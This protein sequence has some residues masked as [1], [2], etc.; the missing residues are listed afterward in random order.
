MVEKIDLKK[1]ERKVYVFY[2][3]DRLINVFSGLL[4][5]SFNVWLILDMAWMGWILIIVDSFLF[6]FKESVYD[7]ED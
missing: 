1:I 7:S 6:C 3:R 5:L 2:Y 4:I